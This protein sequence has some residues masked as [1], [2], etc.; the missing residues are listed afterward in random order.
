MEYS[1]LATAVLLCCQIDKLEQRIVMFSKRSE[2]FR[3][4]PLPLG[5]LSLQKKCK[6]RH[7]LILSLEC[8]IVAVDGLFFFPFDILFRNIASINQV[9]T[10][11]MS[12]V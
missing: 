1:C 11:L 10:S 8:C 5:S 2:T 3:T 6:I 4:M 12:C 7:Y 9:S